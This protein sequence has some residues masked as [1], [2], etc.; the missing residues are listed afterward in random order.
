MS[1]LGVHPLRC[2]HV[3]ITPGIWRIRAA[4]AVGGPA[5]RRI[6]RFPAAL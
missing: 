4:L 3:N 2:P 1:T 6:G 5:R